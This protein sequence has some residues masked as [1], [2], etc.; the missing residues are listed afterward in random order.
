MAK[1]VAICAVAQTPFESNMWYKRFQDMAF[2]VVAP[3]LNETGV[4]F[5]EEKGISTVVTCS[6]DVYDARTI[7]DNAMTDA[8]G[9]HFR[10]EEKVAMDGINAIGYGLACILSGHT[11]L[12]LIVGH[13]KESQPES[14]NMCA[15]LAF[16]PFY[17]RPLGLDF[18]NVAALQARAYMERAGI[19]DEHLAQVVVRSRRNAAKN[20]LANAKEPLSHEEV[21]KSPMLCDP[22]RKLHAYPVSDGAIAM[23]LA[24]EERAKEFT[25]NPVWISGFANCMDSYF[26]GDKD[27]VENVSLKRA[28][29]R[30]YS[31]AGVKEPSNEFDLV[32]VNDCFAYQLPMWA[33]GLGICEESKGGAWIRD[34][35]MEK[36]NLNLSGGMLAGNP[37]MIGGLARAAEAI[38][39][40]RG[41]ADGRQVQGAKKALA[42]GTTGAAGQF[43]SVLILEKA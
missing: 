11:E 19:T 21:I 17:Y 42:H 30:A 6:D 15:N 14:R 41:E 27:L 24:C 37:V 2:D 10:C 13:C 35:G 33:E 26:L 18:L 23:L 29:G 5:D 8:V 39:Q 7:S 16:D 40:L 36:N 12:V 25:D 43:H 4:T 31:M 1:R 9:A 28:A 38:L 32:E 3:I 22:I 20:P 34:Q